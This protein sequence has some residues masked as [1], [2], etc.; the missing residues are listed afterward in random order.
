MADGT[1]G[2]VKLRRRTRKTTGLRSADERLKHWS[3]RWT[4]G[5]QVL[6]LIKMIPQTMTNADSIRRQPNR[7]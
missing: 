2:E 1:G 4:L 7:S 3:R 6:T 5:H